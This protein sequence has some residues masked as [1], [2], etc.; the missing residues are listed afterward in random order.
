MQLISLGLGGFPPCAASLGSEYLMCCGKWRKNS[1]GSA[2]QFSPFP[3]VSGDSSVHISIH[4]FIDHICG[5]PSL[6]QVRSSGT[7]KAAMDIT[8][9][10]L[11]YKALVLVGEANQRKSISHKCP[12]N[13]GTV[14][15]KVMRIVF[16]IG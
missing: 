12:A 4:A 1:G 13:Q 8:E 14:R 6:C 11:F 9:L 16:S 15:D 7:E 5:L 3:T 10:L 2:R